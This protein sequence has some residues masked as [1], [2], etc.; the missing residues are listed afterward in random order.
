MRVLVVGDTHGNRRWWEFGVLPCAERHEVDLICQVGDFGYWP[1][2][3]GRGDAFLEA[4]SAS[5]VPVLFVDG[6]HEDHVALAAAVAEVR[7]RTPLNPTSPVPLGGSLV[8]LPRGARLL[9]DGVRVAALG[10]AHSIDRR[11][12]RPGVDWFKE[13]SLTL[14]DLA[15]LASGGPADLLL[16]HDVPAAAP[17]EGI[18]VDDMPTAW[19]SELADSY[20]HRLLVQDG[21]D[22]VRPWT[23]IH[24]HFHTS[25][26]HRLERPWGAC[27]VHGLDRDGAGEGAFALVECVDGALTCTRLTRTDDRV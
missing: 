11:L 22:A 27:D 23:L 19:L 14:E 25:W 20:A 9:W 7:A 24:G 5:P 10:G 4:V 1:N 12:R 17:V 3:L 2:R 15:L 18:P 21:L 6:N 16:T 8:Y 26:Y 13:E